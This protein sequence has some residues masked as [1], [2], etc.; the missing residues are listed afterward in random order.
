MAHDPA[1]IVRAIYDTWN[2]GDWGMELFHPDVEFQVV[3]RGALDQSAPTRDRDALFEYFRQFWSAW[4]RGGIWAMDVRALEAG[5]VV[6]TGELRVTG[7]SSGI[8]S[9]L[10]QTHLWT[11]RDGL[12]ARLLT[13]DDPDELLGTGG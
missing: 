10:R 1:E 4:K 6:A 2:G 7:R 11:V 9:E 5:L 13:A 3:G 8:D 12:V